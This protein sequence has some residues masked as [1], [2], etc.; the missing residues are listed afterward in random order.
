MTAFDARI[1]NTGLSSEE[2]GRRFWGSRR[3]RVALAY[4]FVAV[5]LGLAVTDVCRLTWAQDSTVS[6][7]GRV[8]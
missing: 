6:L 3:L 7:P 1:E 8:R 2:Y 4:G 5:A